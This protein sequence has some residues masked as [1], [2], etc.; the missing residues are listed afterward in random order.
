MSTGQ[1]NPLRNPD[2]HERACRHSTE[3]ITERCVYP[4]ATSARLSGMS[5]YAGLFHRYHVTVRGT[6][7]ISPDTVHEGAD[8][9]R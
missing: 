7:L 9:W 2:R 1:A 6:E 8:Q 5:R 3:A 4:D